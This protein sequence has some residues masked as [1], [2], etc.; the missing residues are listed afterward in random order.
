[1]KKVKYHFISTYREATKFYALSWSAASTALDLTLINEWFEWLACTIPSVN[2]REQLP[3]QFRL[4]TLELPLTL[5]RQPQQ[6]AQPGAGLP[7]A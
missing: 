6:A 1:M 5:Q 7:T 4:D 3:V 2:A